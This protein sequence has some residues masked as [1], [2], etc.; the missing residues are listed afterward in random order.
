MTTTDASSVSARR[1]VLTR[2]LDAVD[3]RDGERAAALFVQDGAWD[4]NTVAYG[5]VRGRAAVTQL[6][7]ERLPPNPLLRHQ[8]LDGLKVLSP[9][10]ETVEFEIALD[11]TKIKS[12]VRHVLEGVPAQHYPAPHQQKIC[13]LQ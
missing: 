5:T 7:N 11:E 4:T 3:S 13:A 2:F 9:T 6:V 12:I 10:G 8:L 1:E